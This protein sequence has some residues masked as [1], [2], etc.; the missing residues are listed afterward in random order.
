VRHFIDRHADKITGVINGFDRIV[1]R[2]IIRG[3]C[4]PA[5]VGAF[6]RSQDVLLKHFGKF[7]ESVTAM[8]R[9]GAKHVADRIGIPI[10]YLESSTDSKEEIARAF[11]AQRPT[12]PGP[13]CLLSAVE[14]CWSW[15]VRRSAKRE[16]PQDLRRYSTK[17]LHHY[18][19]FF[20][21]EFGFGHVRIQTWMP[22]SVQICLN[23][24]EWLAR[25]LQRSRL[26]HTRVGNCFPQIASPQRAQDIFDRMPGLPW[27]RILSDLV[28][29]ANPAMAT[30][31]HDFRTAYY[32]TVH[33]AEWATDVLFRDPSSLASSYPALVRHAITDF[34]T[35]DVLRFLGKRNIPVSA[36][37][38]SEYKHRTEGVR[39]RHLARSN[40]VK[41]YD[42][43]ASVLRV[44]TTVNRVDEFKVRRKAHGDPSSPSRIREMR[45]G[46]A[47]IRQ[48]ARVAQGC[49]DRYLDALSVVDDDATVADVVL[50]LTRPGSIGGRRVRGL[51]PWADPDLPLL[52]A[53]AA[54]EFFLNGFRNR[55]I[56]AKLFPGEHAPDQRKRLRARVTR[57]LRLL[58]AHDVVE[59]TPGTHR[60]HVTDSGRR[61]VA[62]VLA[63]GDAPLS[64]LKQCA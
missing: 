42:K 14:P 61:L 5:G 43:A 3:L 46:V 44:E 58:R 15:Q 23:G 12:R 37:V 59:R 53:I 55:D 29:R 30:I 48:L 63:A 20:D 35:R 22:Y 24:R 52:R 19:Y 36:D 41:M 27:P 56:L 13:I 64:R 7:V 57:F 31:L 11:F 40:S 9:D 39:V 6:L 8:V 32:W 33:Q 34:G 4:Y 1:F 51:E 54:G 60:Y 2:G 38:T 26:R 10:R 50:P 17:C 28:I 47:D 45:R 18:H 16:H 62:A 49:N 25:Q 21:R